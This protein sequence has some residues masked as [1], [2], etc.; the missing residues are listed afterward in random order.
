MNTRESRPTPSRSAP[1]FPDPAALAELLTAHLPACRED[2]RRVASVA[3]REIVTGRRATVFGIAD[4]AFVEPEGDR[5]SS[6]RVVLQRFGLGPAAVAEG[7]KVFRR[8][9]QRVR[10]TAR[11]AAYRSYAAYLREG[12]LLVSPFPFDYRLETLTEAIDPITAAPVLARLCGVPSLASC[13]AT[14]VR[15]VP[16]KRCQIRYDLTL[17]DG[18]ARSMFGK[19]M[20]D[21]RGAEV[22]ARMRTLQRAFPPEGRVS[23]PASLGYVREWRLLA[24]EAVPGITL[25]DRQ[26]AGCVCLDAYEEVGDALARLHGTPLEG[27][28]PHA[29]PEECALLEVSLTKRTLTPG[30]HDA[31]AALSARLRALAP[32]VAMRPLVT[33]HRDFY[34]KQVLT[35]G[36][37]FWLIDFDTLAVSPRE[38]DLGNFIAH[39]RL[40]AEQGHITPVAAAG[41]GDALLDGYRRRHAIDA[42]A[43]AW[44]TAATFLRLA[45]IYAVRPGCE[46]VPARLIAAAQ[47]A[48][49]APSRARAPHPMRAARES[50]G[51]AEPRS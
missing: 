38:L 19:V 49:G 2:G 48:V 18:S 6:R 16:E 8:L 7:A 21:G 41:I 12:G 20:S 3:V 35:D 43:L 47:E 32:R 27:L 46:H 50:M 15:Y 28:M 1:A 14:P 23:V 31:A 33:S 24:Q 40:R 30:L 4:V 34:D 22:A 11:R 26:H 36:R 37:R 29:A 17:P 39:A 44:F 42:E 25:Y 5:L 51:A 45:T 13:L 10:G 9:R